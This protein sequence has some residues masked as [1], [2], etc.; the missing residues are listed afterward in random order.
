[1]VGDLAYSLLLDGG[2]V[3]SQDELLRGRRKVCQTGDWQILVVQ[4]GVIAESVVG[5]AS[6][7]SAC[8]R[9]QLLRGKSPRGS[10]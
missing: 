3:P 9:A 2:A 1:M 4:V 6:T 5:L 7:S 8:L 10:R